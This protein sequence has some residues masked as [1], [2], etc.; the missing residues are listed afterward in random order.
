MRYAVNV[1]VTY[2]D[3]IMV[4]ADSEDGAGLEAVTFVMRN[5]SDTKTISILSIQKL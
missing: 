3:G 5:T 2:E 1:K 4:E